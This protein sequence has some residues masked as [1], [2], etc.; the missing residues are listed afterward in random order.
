M[1]RPLMYMLADLNQDG[2]KDLILANRETSKILS[3]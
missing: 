1:M 3:T 2:Q